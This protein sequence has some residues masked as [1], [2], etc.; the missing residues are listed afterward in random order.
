MKTLAKIMT[1]TLLIILVFSVTHIQAQNQ[2]T[3]RYIVTLRGP[4]GNAV[5][6]AGGQV[7]HQYKT[8]PAIS[9]TIPNAALNGLA[10]NPN[11][12]TIEPDVLAWASAQTKKTPPGLAKKP[13]PSPD[14]EPDPIIDTEIPWGVDRIDAEEVWNN[15]TGSGINVA[16]IDTGIDYNH[17]DL[18]GKYS[19][20]IDYVNIDNDPMDDMGHGTHVAGTIAA[21]KNDS[22]VVGVAPGV[23]LYAVKVLDSSG[24]GWISDIM[25]GIEWC[26]DKEDIDVINMSL[27]GYPTPGSL[28]DLEFEAVCDSALASGIIVV[29]AAG[30]ESLPYPSAPAIYDSVISVGATKDSDR[31][32]SFSNRG[33]DIA[34]PGVSILSTL[35]GNSYA[36]WSGTSM[37]CPH[38]VGTLALWLNSGPELVPNT[39]PELEALITA[40][41]ISADGRYDIIDAEEAVLGTQNGDN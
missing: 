35:P 29:A 8:I 10:R 19:G 31:L 13:Q 23:S 7:I 4:L 27:G 37:A 24:S 34:A 40:L 36:S 5:Q 15:Y 22:G 20:G 18:A 30:N 1:V 17:K 21:I 3:G 12:L 16:I 39:I 41:Q 2:N 25:A 32:A 38:V 11:V 9:I 14:P 28:L 26:T 33:F 6:R